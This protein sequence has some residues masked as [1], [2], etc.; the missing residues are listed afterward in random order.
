MNAKEQ[1][2][3]FKEMEV[4]NI[5]IGKSLDDPHRVTIILKFQNFKMFL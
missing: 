4:K 1:H 2:A 5:Y 3:M